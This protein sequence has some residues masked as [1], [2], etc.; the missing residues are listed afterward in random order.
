MPTLPPDP[1]VPADQDDPLKRE[2]DALSLQLLGVP[3]LRQGGQVLPCRPA[4]LRLLAV[5]ALD[6]P[7][8]RLTL[9]DRLWET[10]S[11][12]AL[13]NLRMALHHLRKTLGDQAGVLEQRGPLL[14]LDLRRV[15][16]DARCPPTDT[17]VLGP[18]P[19]LLQGHRTRGSEAW[20]EWAAR[21]EERLLSGWTERLLA[22]ARAGES[23]EARTCWQALARLHPDHP[24]LPGAAAPS[25]SSGGAARSPRGD[26]DA[27]WTALQAYRTWR[28]ADA[29]QLARTLLRENGQGNAAALALSVL[30]NI[31]LD[32][33][34]YWRGRAYAEQAVTL[35]PTPGVEVSFTAAYANNLLADFG[36]AERY[37]VDGLRTLAP[38]DSPALLYAVLGKV[39]DVRRDPRT[40]RLWYERGLQ[41]AHGSGCPHTLS[42]VISLM[43][44]HLM[45]TR[46]PARARALAHEGLDHGAPE[47]ARYLVN[48]LGYAQMASGE[49]DGAL[50]VFAPQRASGNTTLAATAH[51]MTAVLL[52][53]LGEEQAAQEC[54]GQAL[55]LAR[56]SECEAVR[57]E[58]VASAATVDAA[59]WQ[60][61]VRAVS[62]GLGP[63]GWELLPFYRQLVAAPSR[64]R[65]TGRQR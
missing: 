36:R 19:G 64:S 5:L 61:E 63:R 8:D 56:L 18:W 43:G 33:G 34:E 10:T 41:A 46:E 1:P 49:P 13:H 28:T 16:V 40:A 17:E 14:G 22:R 55:A 62:Q 50:N 29:E 51:S 31:A 7:Q 65:S 30:A 12:H 2:G 20:L 15:K 44:Y 52:H 6:G 39:S 35:S 9:A 32:Y 53:R 25:P 3:A 24:A 42:Q 4:G 57:A 37:A 48:P 27:A 58:W 47:F 45:H 21:H 60:S 54:L 38:T 11:D 26:E 59:T 23:C